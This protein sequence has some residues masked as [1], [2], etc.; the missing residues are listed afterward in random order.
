[1][2]KIDERSINTIRFLSVDAV[3]KAN[4]GHP[5]LPMGAAPM[6]YT[7][8]SKFLR[9]SPQN[10]N[11]ENRDRFVLSAGHGSMLLYSLLHL[12]KYDLPMEELKNFRQLGSKTPGHPEYGHTQGVE[13]TTGPLGQGFANS[14]G[15]AIAE[16]HLG[17]KFN[18][19][20]FKIVD[21]NTY[22]IAGDGDM[23]EGITYEAASLAGTLGL[24]K[25]IVLYDDNSITID[26][27]TDISFNEDVRKR[28][29]SF[30]WNVI[31]VKDGN[32]ISQIRKA[33]LKA[34]KSKGKPTLIMVKTIIGF[35]SP[36]KAGTSKVHGAPLGAEETKLTREALG[37]EYEEFEI[38]QDVAD[39][40][41]KLVKRKEKYFK[42]WHN[43]MVDY[44]KENPELYKQWKVWHSNKISDGLIND[45]KLL[46]D[47]TGSVATR[48]AGGEIL[49]IIAGHI[50]NIMGG[51]ADL[52]ES[53]KTYLKDKGDFLSDGL[54]AN[55]F[56]GIREHAMGAIVNGIVLHGGLR[57]FGSTFLVFSD[58]MRT[59]IR[60]ASLM[61]IPSMF[62]FTHDSIG[63]GEDGPTHQ[64]IE[65]VM[66]LRAIPG[67]SVWRPA[68]YNETRHAYMSAFE[69]SD[70]PSIMVLTRQNLP[71][72]QG[73]SEDV[74]KGGYILVKEEGEKADVILMGSGS[75]VHILIAAAKML[76]KENI[77]AR[78][79]SMPNI[80]VFEE[81]TEEYIESVL[82]RNIKARV[83][84]ESGTTAGWY[85][86]VG[87]DGIAIGMDTF[88][89]S[90]PIEG[91][92]SHFGFTAD[93]VTEKAKK[94]I[95]HAS[96]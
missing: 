69:K 72:L 78:V 9:I 90:A 16:R 88:G 94:S 52:N 34:Q 74:K 49:N 95:E 47:K 84:V 86:Y 20:K 77:D 31:T 87:L 57:A 58:Y 15:M 48:S 83:S 40:F 25:L 38:P 46:E 6:G 21:H 82:P 18:T 85:R 68:D 27:A 42:Q 66:S 92:M 11:W 32:D 14:V 13:T 64:P 33:I 62:I 23:M 80:N 76:K 37:W 91:L 28:F 63:V 5:G 61:N 55:I 35:G 24:E 30:K 70:G 54:G 73:V 43:T 71:V 36:N 65:H 50:P 26:G 81:Q 79:V 22:C 1:M 39:N 96:K 67:S 53:T 17:A 59:P 51:S 4:S 19:P 41:D 60:L 7:L 56:F 2:K 89:A 75:E 29:E 12:F 8:W 45:P 3:N 44:A 10:P 93:N